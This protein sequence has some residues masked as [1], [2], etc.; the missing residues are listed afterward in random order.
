MSSSAADIQ[1]L[2][3]R[4]LRDSPVRMYYFIGPGAAVSAALNYSRPVY[5]TERLSFRQLRENPNRLY[6]ESGGIWQTHRT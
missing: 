3:E 5:R 6:G 2:L 1:F 4:T